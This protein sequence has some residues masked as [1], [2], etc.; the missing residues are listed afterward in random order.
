MGTVKL[1]KARV[2]TLSQNCKDL[3][4]EHIH[5]EVPIIRGRAE[6]FQV[7]VQFGMIGAGFLLSVPPG[8]PRP[9]GTVLS[10]LGREA[11]CMVLGDYADALTKAGVLDLPDSIS[12]LR[13]ALFQAVPAETA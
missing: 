6:R 7:A 5:G 13:K 9:R 11:V 2:R 3:L 10:H 4:I 12:A 8:S 1:T